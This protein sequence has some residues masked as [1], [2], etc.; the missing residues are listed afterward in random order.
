MIIDTKDY[1][2]AKLTVLIFGA[3]GPQPAGRSGAGADRYTYTHMCVY[4]YIYIY[5][6]IHIIYI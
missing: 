5:T 3:A 1:F 6:Y 2:C 4:I